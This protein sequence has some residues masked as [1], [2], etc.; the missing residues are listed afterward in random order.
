M[1]GNPNAFPHFNTAYQLGGSKNVWVTGEYGLLGLWV[2]RESTVSRSSCLQL[3][4]E[5]F[6]WSSL[7]GHILCRILFTILVR[8]TFELATVTFSSSGSWSWASVWLGHRYSYILI[9][10]PLHGHDTTYVLTVCCALYICALYITAML[11][12]YLTVEQ[13]ARSY[14]PYCCNC[15][16]GMQKH[17]SIHGSNNG[18]CNCR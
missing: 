3:M 8:S 2:M 13:V 10:L 18:T 4:S 12:L 16:S 9:G 6:K 1:S 7:S 5:H 15:L 14:C 11:S 17:D